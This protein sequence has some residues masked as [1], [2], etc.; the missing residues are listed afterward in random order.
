MLGLSSMDEDE[1][2]LVGDGGYEV[3]ASQSPGCHPEKRPCLENV[4]AE[5][6]RSIE[7]RLFSSP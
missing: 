1:Q 2:R 7:V 3:E 6:E 5:E 4:E